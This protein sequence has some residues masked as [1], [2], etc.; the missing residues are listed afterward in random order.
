MKLFGKKKK[1]E[2]MDDRTPIERKFEEKGQEIGKQAGVLAQKG[3]D[4]FNEV[5]DRLDEEGKLDGIKSF[6]EKA[7][8][9][10]REVSEVVS[11]KAREVFSKNDEDE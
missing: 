6:T 2:P 11:S 10:S 4:K 3:V 7:K 5:K 1:E 9:K 8:L